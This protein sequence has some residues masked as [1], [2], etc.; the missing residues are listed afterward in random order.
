MLKHQIRKKNKNCQS[1]KNSYR[2][3]NLIEKKLTDDEVVKK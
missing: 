3:S 2:E 1:E